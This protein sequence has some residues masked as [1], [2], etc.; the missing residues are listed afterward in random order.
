MPFSKQTSVIALSLYSLYLSRFVIRFFLVRWYFTSCWKLF[1][2]I[3]PVTLIAGVFYDCDIL[4]FRH[5]RDLP[6]SQWPDKF[7]R[8]QCC[9]SGMVQ[10]LLLATSSLILNTCEIGRSE[11]LFWCLHILKESTAMC[12]A[13]HHSALLLWPVC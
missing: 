5:N 8:I 9:A 4:S 7:C 6:G 11:R 1:V 3:Y 12:F 13:E 10:H 2:L